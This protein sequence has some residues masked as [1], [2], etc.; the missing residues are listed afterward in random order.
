ESRDDEDDVHDNSSLDVR[1]KVKKVFK[2]WLGRIYDGGKV[3]IV[4]LVGF[5]EVSV[6]EMDSLMKIEDGNVLVDEESIIEEPD[7]EV[8][9][10]EVSKGEHIGIIGNSSVR[11]DDL[12]LK[13]NLDVIDNNE[14]ENDCDSEGDVDYVRKKKLKEYMK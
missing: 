4:D 8:T 10:F 9:L 12:I 2:K 5:D 7:V 1:Y 6:E 11:H 3:N 13:N 14:F